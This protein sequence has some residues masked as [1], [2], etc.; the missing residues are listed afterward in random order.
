MLNPSE[1]PEVLA[2]PTPHPHA[3]TAAAVASAGLIALAV[4]MGVGR[5]AFTPLLPMMQDDAGLSVVAGGWLAS[6]NYLGYL[7]GALAATWLRLRTR[8]AIRG[9][10]VLIGLVTLGM[11][12]TNSFAVWFALRLAAGVASAWVLIHISTWALDHLA[13]FRRPILSGV[14]FGGVGA[15][16]AGVGA[17]CVALMYAKASSAQTWILFGVLCLGLTAMIWPRFRLDQSTPGS[18]VH[19]AEKESLEWDGETIR[20]T[21]CYAAF[22]FGYIIPATFLPVMAKQIIHDPLVFG[23]SWPV[24]GLAAFASTLAATGFLQRWMSNRQV[25]GSSQLVMAVGVGL[26]VVWPGIAG[27]LVSAL[28]VGGTFVVTT[29]F[30]LK[31][32]REVGG[33]HA[34]S[35]IAVMTAAFATGQIAGPIC[36]SYL[37]RIT[38]TLSVALIIASVLL[39]VSTLG[40]SRRSSK[41]AGRDRERK[42]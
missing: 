16:I 21:L 3:L 17:L 33:R 23:W 31:E 42:I 27:I 36:V 5:F 11:G 34:T 30:A 14:V 8:T 12:F 1:V 18:G 41:L 37:V 10:L 20:L 28:L 9:G 32:G 6:A 29:M 40:L 7:L 38:G 2:S 19:N 24:F 35:L 22:G 25:W 4:A 26:P 15:G 13:P 39:A